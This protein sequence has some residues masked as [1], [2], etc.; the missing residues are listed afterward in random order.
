MKTT[1]DLPEALLYRAKVVAAERRTTLKELV[2]LGLEYA[3]RNQLPDVETERKKRNQTLL[4][5]L[6]EIRITDPVGTLKREETYDRHE[7]RWE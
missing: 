4:E 3:T 6:S 1:I 7:G 5:A 2:V